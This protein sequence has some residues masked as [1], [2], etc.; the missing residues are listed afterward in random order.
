MQPFLI[1]IYLRTCIYGHII[2]R[3][4]ILIFTESLNRRVS[5]LAF[6]IINSHYNTPLAP[7]MH[8]SEQ[9][10][11]W[12]RQEQCDRHWDFFQPQL[13]KGAWR[14]RIPCC[15]WHQL[16]TLS[17]PSIFSF[18]SHLWVSPDTI[19]LPGNGH[20]QSL[21][22]MLRF[23]TFFCIRLRTTLFCSIYADMQIPWT[24]D[25]LPWSDYENVRFPVEALEGLP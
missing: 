9:F 7:P 24:V 3:L 8:I 10:K 20:G 21:D 17:L 12:D 13:G 18:W 2:I 15:D 1:S 14:W 23:Q 6:I 11:F 4:F 19:P 22:V 16:I 5:I 25:I